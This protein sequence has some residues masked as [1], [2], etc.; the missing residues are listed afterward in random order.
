MKYLKEAVLLAGLVGLPACD[1]G[2]INWAEDIFEQSKTHDIDKKLVKKYLKSVR[3]YDQFDTIAIFDVLWLS[4]DIRG[5]YSHLHT[6]MSGIH[7]EAST[8]FLRRQFKA[9]EHY[10]IFY[11]LSTDDIVLNAIPAP[12]MIHIKLGEKTYTPL[13]V[14]SLEMSPEYKTI[15]GSLLTNHKRPYEVKFDR[16]DPDGKD[17]MNTD[18]KTMTFSMSSPSHYVSLDFS[19][20]GQITYLI[21]ENKNQKSAES[22]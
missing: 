2:V 8:A 6:T 13:E 17:I 20:E 4:N 19:V 1:R 7:K 9:N 5:V 3:V 15:F 22:K 12:W 21:P 14:K 10:L 18:I 16:K 11:I